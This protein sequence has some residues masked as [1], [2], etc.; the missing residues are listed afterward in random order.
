MLVLETDEPHPE[1]M[2]HRGRFGEIMDRLFRAA[3]DRHDPPLGIETDMRFI[4]DDPANGHH[5]KVPRA[6]DISDKTTA[7]LITG[8]MYDAHGDDPW[9]TETI[10]LIEELWRT[11]PNMRFSG[12]CFGHQILARTL[13]ARVEATP[14]EKWELSHTSM[15]LSPVGK[16]LFLTEDDT[17]SV[18]QMHQDQV[19]TVPS[20]ETSDLLGKDQRVHIWAS[21]KH[22]K[23][24]GLYIRDRL[25]TSQGHLGFDEKM[26]RRQIELRQKSGAIDENDAAEVQD[27]EETAHLEH[28]GEIVAA[29]V[30]RFFHGDDHNID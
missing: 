15:E 1:T 21:T 24:Q 20:S 25:F 16:K 11:R 23:I 19:T 17:I 30:L 6:A 29:A 8:S 13:G 18:H 14:G 9:I 7:I 3:G 28:D 4:V 22:T 2:K 27:A 12:I 26:V 10:S 5:G